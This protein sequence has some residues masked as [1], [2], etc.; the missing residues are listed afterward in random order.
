MPGPKPVPSV[1]GGNNQPQKETVKDLHDIL[2]SREE[3]HSRICEVECPDPAHEEFCRNLIERLNN[4]EYRHEM[5]PWLRLNAEAAK[6]IEECKENV[7]LECDCN[8][9]RFS[10]EI[11][12]DA[13]L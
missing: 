9:L 10:V 3:I 2:S 11:P 13:S 1:P 4:G 7:T 6:A 8:D 12:A 5:K